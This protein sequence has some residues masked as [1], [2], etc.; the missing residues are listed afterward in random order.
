MN[1]KF[2]LY[3]KQVK[4]RKFKIINY[5]KYVFNQEQELNDKINELQ[6]INESKIFQIYTN[7]MIIINKISKLK[8]KMNNKKM[9]ILK[10]K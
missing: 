1:K 4:F 10:I 8:F 6:T 2:T 3:L 7:E 5:Y 9:K